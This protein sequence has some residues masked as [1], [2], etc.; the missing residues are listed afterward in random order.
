[1]HAIYIPIDDGGKG[2][3]I[4]HRHKDMAS[5]YFQYNPR[6]YKVQSLNK[7]AYDAFGTGD[8]SSHIPNSVVNNVEFRKRESWPTSWRWAVFCV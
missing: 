4:L 3:F 2:V 6:W 7:Y 8:H 5:R 1:M